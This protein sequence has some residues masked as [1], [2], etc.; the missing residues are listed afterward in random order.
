MDNRSFWILAVGVG[1]FLLL[2]GLKKAGQIS[3]SAARRWRQQGAKVVDVRSHDEF[4]GG[5]VR[6]AVNVPLDELAERIRTVAPDPNAPLLLHCLSGTRSAI[7][8][9]RLRAM[10]YTQVFNLGSLGRTRKIVES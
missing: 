5:H 7:A 3:E 10:G 6:G 9:R 1:L 8:R 4:N 2:L